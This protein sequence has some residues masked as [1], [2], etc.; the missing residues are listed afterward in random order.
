M[1]WFQLICLCSACGADSIMSSFFRGSLSNL[2]SHNR[3][4][5]VVNILIPSWWDKSRWKI[6]M[7]FGASSV[8]LVFSWWKSVSIFVRDE[9]GVFILLSLIWLDILVLLFV[10]LII[11]P[12]FQFWV[13][14]C[15]FL[16]NISIFWMT[17]TVHSFCQSVHLLF[18]NFAFYRCI[19]AWYISN[20][21]FYYII[22][23][24][25]YY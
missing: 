14:I 12:I 9:N 15:L 11:A 16:Q 20:F 8:I 5:S 4:L 17:L 7:F 18:L 6:S 22:L 24:I 23:M 10:F 21:T 25:N 3:S 19:L 1:S 13:K 2:T